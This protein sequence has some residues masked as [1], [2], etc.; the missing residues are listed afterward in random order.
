MAFPCGFQEVFPTADAM[1]FRQNA[2]KTG[3]NVVQISLRFKHF[4]GLNLLEYEFKMLFKTGKQILCNF[5]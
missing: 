3:N 2:R 5:I 4:T 1:L